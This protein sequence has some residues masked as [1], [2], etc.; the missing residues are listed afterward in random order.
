MKKIKKHKKRI[1][2]SCNFNKKEIFGNYSVERPLKETISLCMIVKNEEKNLKRCLMSVKPV[3]DEII[4]VD[5]GS[6]DNTKQIAKNFE[7]KIF[8]FPWTYNFSD[9]RNFSLSKVCAK[10]ILVLD[11]DEVISAFDH[12]RLR[13]VVLNSSSTQIAYRMIT[14]NYVNSTGTIDWIANDGRYIVEEAGS[15]WFPS[16]KVR[17]FP[18][19]SQIQFKG[20]VHEM[21]EDSLLMLGMEIKQCDIPIHHYGKLSAE[22]TRTKREVYYAL[23]Q[24]KLLELG[25]HDI[26]ATFE[27]A[28]LAL[29]LGRHE[30]SLTYWKK[31]TALRPD[32]ADAF[33]YMGITYFKLGMFEEALFSL[34]KALQI[35]PFSA[36]IVTVYSKYQI[37]AGYAENSI[38]YLEKLLSIFPSDPKAIAALAVAYLC[39][40]KKDKGLAYI[41]KL[42][43]MRFDC[44]DY[45][46]ENAKTLISA[47]QTTYAILLLEGAVESGNTNA[48]TFALLTQCHQQR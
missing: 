44:T 13:K 37:I 2:T 41:K 28:V 36:N 8:D 22:E 17:L 27:I 5:T 26:N 38:L 31:L 9:A 45:F 19:N 18:N 42:S 20:A 46:C 33:Y 43:D 32:F 7:A 35:D 29:E 23:E 1:S 48:D 3:V 12:E 6:S 21:V 39:T 47:G 25:E 4:I 11:A 30:E 10:W 34:E 15:G 24:K 14:R 16:E 40:A